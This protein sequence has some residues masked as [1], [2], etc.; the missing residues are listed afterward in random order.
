ML[1]LQQFIQVFT[2]AAT[3]ENSKDKDREPEFRALIG[4][5]I[6]FNWLLFIPLINFPLCHEIKE[7]LTRKITYK[8]VTV[9][10]LYLISI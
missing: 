10:F 2:K 7:R 4:G 3:L 8:V 5:I 9:V 1:V 6:R